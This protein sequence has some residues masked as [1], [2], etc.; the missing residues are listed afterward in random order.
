MFYILFGDTYKLN[1]NIAKIRQIQ[2]KIPMFRDFPITESATQFKL[3]R[4]KPM[5]EI[6]MLLVLI[7]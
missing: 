5:P 3:H 4:V 7:N 6:I 2:N 1:T